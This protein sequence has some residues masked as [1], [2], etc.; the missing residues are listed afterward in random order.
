[1]SKNSQIEILTRVVALMMAEG[2]TDKADEILAWASDTPKAVA[3]K[4]PKDWTPSFT[5]KYLTPYAPFNNEKVERFI[6]RAIV[7]KPLHVDQERVKR[8][9]ENMPYA[10]FL[11]TIYWRGV[12]LFVKRRDGWRCTECGSTKKIEVHHKTY[13]NH[14]AETEHLEDLMTLCDNCHKKAHKLEKPESAEKKPASVAETRVRVRTRRPKTGSALSLSD[15]VNEKEIE[16]AWN[17]LV[18]KCSYRPRVS[19]ALAKSTVTIHE[20]EN[21][22][23]IIVFTL[24]NEAQVRWVEEKFLRDME[25]DLKEIVGREDIELRVKVRQS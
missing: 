8:T 22:K 19:S 16:D 13:E 23:Q 21:G 9:I 17:A 7:N 12:S 5:K 3:E 10:D 18:E 11:N 24:T 2:D 25:R 6:L 4:K 1:M 20:P 15:I 14:G